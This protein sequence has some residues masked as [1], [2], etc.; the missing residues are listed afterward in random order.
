MNRLVGIDTRPPAHLD[1]DEIR[2]ETKEIC[3]EIADLAHQMYA[4]EKQSL[5]V[6]LQGMD[7]SGKD[8]IVNTV[9]RYVSPNGVSTAPFKKPTDLE[10][11]HDFLW[12]VHQQAP[13]AGEIKVFNRSHYEDILVPSVYGYLDARLIE[14]RFRHINDFERMLEDHGTKI[15]KFYLHVDPQE[16][17]ERL[18]ERMEVEEKFW[19]HSDGDWETVANRDKFLDVYETIFDRCADVPWHIVPADKNWYKS[20]FVAKHVLG[21]LKNMDLNW[22]ELDTEMESIPKK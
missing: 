15:L 10:F 7:A 16:Q 9:F 20:Y 14:K 19:K 11:A 4:Q 12:R 13:K 5:L 3:K 8:G 6:V 18:I 1:K 21:A 22:P 2:D 17:R